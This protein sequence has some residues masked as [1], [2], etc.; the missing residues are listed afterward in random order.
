MAGHSHAKN[1]Q[2]KKSAV[3]KKRS[4]VFGKLLKAITVAARDE[5]NPEFNPTLRSAVEK[6]K[7]NNVPNDSIERAIKK[8]SD[9]DSSDLEELIL[10]AYG[11][12][13]VAILMTAIT[14]N[15]NRTVNEVKA[16]LKKAD[17]KWAESGSVLWAFTKTDE[18]YTPN[19]PQE[20]SKESSEKLQKIIDSLE[21]NDDITNIIT[22]SKQ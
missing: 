17:A 22:S 21:E 14:D 1:V 5:S 7:Q 2:H 15:S 20:I 16:I 3:D 4:A 11:P 13:G 12:E 19:F 6:A 18:G 9:K 10:E 8:S